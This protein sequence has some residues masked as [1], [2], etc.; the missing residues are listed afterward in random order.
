MIVVEDMYT[1][2]HSFVKELTSFK[3]EKLRT[4]CSQ[5]YD[6]H[7]W[8]AKCSFYGQ[9]FLNYH[10]SAF[11]SASKSAITVQKS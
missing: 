4:L 5:E 7:A 1:H 8:D 11:Y 2:F 9:H 3:W 10:C 6:S